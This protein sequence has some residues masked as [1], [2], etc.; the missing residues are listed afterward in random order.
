MIPRK[1]YKIN[2]LEFLNLRIMIMVLFSVV[3]VNVQPKCI[4]IRKL[5]SKYFYECVN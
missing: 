4:F 3:L 2:V 5:V 1:T